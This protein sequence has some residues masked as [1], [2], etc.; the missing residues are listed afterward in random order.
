[1]AEEQQEPHVLAIASH[2]CAS[3]SKINPINQLLT[4]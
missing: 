3:I 1:M 2:V 4:I